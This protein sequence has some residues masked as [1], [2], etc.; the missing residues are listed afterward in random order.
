MQEDTPSR[1]STP[2]WLV[3]CGWALTVAAALWW[4]TAPGA[5]DG[6]FI[7]VLVVVLAAVS[8]LGSILRPRLRA[9]TTGITLRTPGGTKQWS[10][11]QV[12]VRVRRSQRLGRTVETLELEVPEHDVGG[13]LVVLTKLDLGTDVT[14]VAERLDRI[15]P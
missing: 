2:T 1:W 4:S 12:R 8:V 6:L 7:G 11:D 13:G 5:V 14:E 3:G 15:R 9:D 10:W